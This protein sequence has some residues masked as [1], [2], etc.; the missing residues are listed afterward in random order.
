MELLLL[1]QRRLVAPALLRQHVKQHGVIQALEELEGLNQQRQVVPVD[2]AKVL[3]PEL[4]EEQRGPQHA[5]G[6]LFGAA[7]GRQRRLAAEALH[8]PRRRIVEV[9]VALV[10][11]DPVEVAGNGPHVAVDRPLVVVEHDDQALGLFGDVVHRFERDAVG[12]GG[13]PGYRDHV[14]LAAGQVA[15]HCH[16]Q[17]GRESGSGVA[18]SV[19]IVL[20]F[21]AQHEAVQPA[22]LPDGVKAVQTPGENLVNVGLVADV[23]KQLVVGGVEDIVESQG[24]LDHA[25]I[26]T[27]VTAGLGKRLDEEFADLRCQF[28]HLHDVQTFQVGGRMDGLKQCSHRLPSPGKLPGLQEK[29]PLDAGA[30]RTTLPANSIPMPKNCR[31]PLDE[32]AESLSAEMETEGVGQQAPYFA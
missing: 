32:A 26:G 10:G 30:M 15:G 13:V 27:Q 20:A 19:A 16:A 6:G 31:C 7:H 28:G 2:G 1:V 22:G 14:F 11:H 3:Q 5:L 18:G 21:G 9:L 4:L 23:E 17:G 29:S 24:Q 25:E 12:E 8:Q